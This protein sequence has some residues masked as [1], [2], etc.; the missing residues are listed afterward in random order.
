[1]IIIL[2]TDEKRPF[3]LSFC[4]YEVRREKLKTGDYSILGHENNDGKENFG[5]TIERKSLSDLYGTLSQGRERFKREFERMTKFRFAC[6]V[7]EADL[8]N[9]SKNPPIRSKLPPKNVTQTIW[10]W[11]VKYRIPFVPCPNKEFAARAT[12]RMLE[13]Y[14]R[15]YGAAK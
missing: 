11:M 15:H 3:D 1:M 14:Y 9:I 12:V 13:Q 7:V 10:S 6:V 2:D 5:I 4:D 8:H